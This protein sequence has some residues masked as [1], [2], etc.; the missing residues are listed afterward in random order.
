MK[1][2]A[3]PVRALSHLYDHRTGRL[4]VCSGCVCSSSATFSLDNRGLVCV[5]ALRP[6]QPNRVMSGAVSLPDHT[7]TGQA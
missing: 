3:I 1:I 2:Y 7:F 5:E 4:A 6:S